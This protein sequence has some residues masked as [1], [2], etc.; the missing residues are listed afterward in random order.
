MMKVGFYHTQTLD[1]GQKLNL[2]LEKDFV[3]L[4]ERSED[5]SDNY[6]NPRLEEGVT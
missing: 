5:Q 3:C 6:P 1:D 2:T 4:D